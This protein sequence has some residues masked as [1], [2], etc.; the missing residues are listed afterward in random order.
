[1]RTS[2]IL[3]TACLL[4]IFLIQSAISGGQVATKAFEVVKSGQGKQALIF[5]P[6]FACSGQV[7]DETKVYFEDDYTC[8]TLTMAGFAGVKPQAHPSFECWKDS[9]VQFVYS[10][11][12]EQPVV[13]GHSMGAGLAMALAADH[14]ELISKIV[15]VDGLPCLPALINPEFKA[16]EKPDCTSHVH[17][18]CSVTDSQ[19]YHM[20]KISISQLVSDTSKQ[21]L[22]LDWSLRSD[23]KTLAE[24]YCSF[25]NTDLRRR[26][27]HIQCP[28][29]ILLAA[30]FRGIK[31][32]VEEQ[33]KYLPQADIQY[34]DKALHFIMYDDKAWYVSRLTDFI[35]KP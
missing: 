3:K 16:V 13:I 8:Y 6:G 21:A 7:W 2:G 18:F 30:P 20:Q 34:S 12:I 1:M 25:A 4:S 19:F 24:M 17:Q 23:R 14:P 31:L 33:F 5:I 11:S 35:R 32:A 28:A 27:K 9:I 29:L 22:I 26:I 10:H 15:V